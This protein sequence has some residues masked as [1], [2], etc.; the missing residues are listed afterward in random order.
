MH[1]G[2]TLPLP[3]LQGTFKQL[4]LPHIESA[5]RQITNYLCQDFGD[6]NSHSLRALISMIVRNLLE[7]GRGVLSPLKTFATSNSQRGPFEIILAVYIYLA[8][9]LY[10]FSRP[11]SIRYLKGYFKEPDINMPDMERER[12]EEHPDQ[13]IQGAPI[14][15]WRN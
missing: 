12:A 1:M 8:V 7:F 3:S 9:V 4:I 13:A 5:L 2:F 14:Q 6:Q 11:A 10:A 15:A